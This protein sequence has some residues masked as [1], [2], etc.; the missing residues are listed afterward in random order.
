MASLAAV[1]NWAVAKWQSYQLPAKLSIKLCCLTHVLIYA[2]AYFTYGGHTSVELQTHDPTKQP[3]TVKNIPGLIC[4]TGP[5]ALSG[6]PLIWQYFETDRENPHV[7]ENI[8]ANIWNSLVSIPTMWLSLEWI[9][10]ERVYLID[11]AVV[12]TQEKYATVFMDIMIFLLISDAWFYWS[13]RLFHEVDGL[14]CHHVLHHRLNPAKGVTAIAA[15]STS[16]VD[17]TLTHLPMFWFPFCCKRF[18]FWAVVIA[19]VFMMFWL[20]FIHSA[21]FWKTNTHILM[22]PTNHRVHHCWGRKN[23]YNFG[24]YTLIWDKLMG[25]YRSEADMQAAW[26]KGE[27]VEQ[28]RVVEAAKKGG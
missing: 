27:K 18:E 16:A 22:D 1:S 14:W 12:P 19:L 6:I 3:V 17:L 20:P 7:L 28:A 26:Q 23:N 15:A 5:I 25:T 8:D 24:G 9:F 11:D 4:I 21:S 10:R 13:H 2:A